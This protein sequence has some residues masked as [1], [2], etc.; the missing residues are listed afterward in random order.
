MSSEAH[1]LD[2]VESSQ[3]GEARRLAMLFADRL[4]LSE[5]EQG[6]VALIV[7]ELGTNLVKHAKHGYLLLRMMGDMEG[8]GIELLSVDKG[9]GIANV[10]HAL[11]DGFSTVGTRGQG[12]GAVSRIA[13][14]FDLVTDR[15]KGTVVLAR[16]WC[17]GQRPTQKLIEVGGV[18]VR[19]KSE[20]VCGDGWVV[21][22]DK[23][24]VVLLVVD[25]LGHG[26]LAADAALQA[27][28]TFKRHTSE[29]PT[30]ILNALHAALK[31][32]RGAAGAVCE[33]FPGTQRLSFAGLG[34]IAGTVLTD[35]KRVSV[36]SQ[37]GTL[38]AEARK[39]LAF[40]YPFGQGAVAV[41]A[42]DGI[43]TRWDLTGYPGLL[44]KHPSIVAAVLHRDFARGTD[45]AT[46]LVVRR[47]PG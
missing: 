1:L 5:D 21:Q 31:P 18:C 29:P 24:R 30:D 40:D 37:N 35:S 13:H 47:P 16:L 23:G 10:G 26:Q 7:T 3:V 42:S 33:I 43:S 46:V 45:D 22:H 9:P 41:F 27:S 38:G 2:I 25:G 4:G 36:V 15:E 32:T 17:S 11:H 39:P 20:R 34:N 6:K 12:L 19:L 28:L 44:N 8:D 14:E